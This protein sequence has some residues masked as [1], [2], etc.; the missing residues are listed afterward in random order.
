M[1]VWGQWPRDRPWLAFEIVVNVNLSPTPHTTRHTSHITHIIPPRT[2]REGHSRSCRIST[3][4]TRRQTRVCSSRWARTTPAPAS[5]RCSTLASHSLRAGGRGRRA[6]MGL[7]RRRWGRRAMTATRLQETD[8][9]PT[10]RKRRR[11]RA[12]IR[13]AEPR[14]A[15]CSPSMMTGAALGVRGSGLGKGLGVG[16]WG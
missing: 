8:V 7:W 2:S 15:H 5:C 1:P 11:T 16:F 14:H 10:A 3:G 6:A 13:R 12:Q 9:A 4:G